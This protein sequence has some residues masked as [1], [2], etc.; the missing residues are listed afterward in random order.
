MM[1]EEPQH[2]K[3]GTGSDN[4]IALMAQGGGVTVLS[5]WGSEAYV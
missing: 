3:K 2:T 5:P 4:V 1:R